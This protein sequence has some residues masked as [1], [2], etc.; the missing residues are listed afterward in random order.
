M[1]EKMN[2]EEGNTRRPS[3]RPFP[4]R[5]SDV[6]DGFTLEIDRGSED[7]VTEGQT[8]EIYCEA[9]SAGA[10]TGAGEEPALQ[11]IV[12]GTGVAVRV[13]K[14]SA[15]LASVTPAFIIER[16]SAIPGYLGGPTIELTD[17]TAGKI[18]PFEEPR[19]GDPVRPADTQAEGK[20]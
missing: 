12:K 15:I 16:P 3:A 4:A 7:G 10:E 20:E 14:R 6:L 9:E 17:G 1:H 8:F 5:V 18:A 13:L 11:E 2:P 19:K